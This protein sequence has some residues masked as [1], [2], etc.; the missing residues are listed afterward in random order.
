MLAVFTLCYP[1]AR[2]IPRVKTMQ[3]SRIVAPLLVAVSLA[4]CSEGNSNNSATPTPGESRPALDLTFSA[5]PVELT[6]VTAD[7]AAN[8]AY[9]E[10]E[11]NQFDI[12]I[13]DCE[14]PTPLVIFIHGGGFIDGDK[15]S[16]YEN[17]SDDIHAFLQNCVAYATINYSLLEIPEDEADLPAA[18]DQGGILTSLQDTARALQFMRYHYQSLNLDPENVALYGVSAGAGSSLWLGTHDD[19]AEPENGDPILRESTRIK[20]VGALH[21]QATYDLLDWEDILLPITEPF[22]DV[23]GGTDLPTLAAAVGASN[24]LLTA[25]AVTS[26]EDLYSAD[27]EEYRAEMDMLELMDSGDAPIYTE[28]FEVS[29]DDLLNVLLHHALHALEIKERADEVGLASVAYSG[30]PTYPLEDP[31]GENL[32]SFLTRHIR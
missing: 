4:A 12:F 16:A 23:L 15:S 27:M 11:R 7:F 19:M 20:A 24:Y 17:F 13:P 28:N 31:S 9:G 18:A 26:I 32:V 14:D 2:R 6:N 8:V 25:F 30:D 22:A 1:L 21:T 29:F 3:I 5:P 10:A